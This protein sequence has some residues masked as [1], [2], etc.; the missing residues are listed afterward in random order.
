MVPGSQSASPFDSRHGAPPNEATVMQ[1]AVPPAGATHVATPRVLSSF[2]QSLSSRHG[3]VHTLKL[4][5][6]AAR[7]LPI[8][9]SLSVWHLKPRRPGRP[10]GGAAG[11]EVRR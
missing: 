8:M 9:Q 6:A 2:A 1:W 5:S 10:A 4:V 3:T 11:P 7:Q